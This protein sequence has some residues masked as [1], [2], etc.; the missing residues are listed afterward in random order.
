MAIIIIDGVDLPA[1]SSM[2]IPLADLDSPDTTRN[3]LG[4]LQRDRIRQG[5]HKVELSWNVLTSGEVTTI[6]NAIEPDKF[7]VTF[8]TP[9]GNVTKEM[10]CGDRKLE[11]VLYRN[12]QNPLWSL[13]FNLIEY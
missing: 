9:F 11:A 8:P 7:N 1:P 4:I 10:Y 2:S 13:S 12:G 5:V 6:L 3:E